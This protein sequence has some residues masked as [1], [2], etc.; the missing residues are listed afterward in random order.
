M[1][2]K[3]TINPINQRYPFEMELAK[4][5]PEIVQAHRYA[6]QGLVDS[7]NGI[8]ALKTQLDAALA[9]IAALEGTK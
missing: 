7:Q 3:P 6:F 4:H 5:P 9:R 2:T 1:S 8:K